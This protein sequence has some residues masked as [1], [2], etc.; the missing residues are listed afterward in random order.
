MEIKEFKN[1]IVGDTVYAYNITNFDNTIESFT[2]E[3]IEQDEKLNRTYLTLKRTKIGNDDIKIVLN[4]N[5][6]EMLTVKIYSTIISLYYL[7][8]PEKSV[9]E[10]AR[11]MGCRGVN[12]MKNKIKEAKALM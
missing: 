8:S 6:S 1:V 2:V 7:F 5:S 10:F 12:V 3:S 4:L 11:N 9:C